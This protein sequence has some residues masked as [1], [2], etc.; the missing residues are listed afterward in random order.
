MAKPPPFTPSE[1]EG[2]RNKWCQKR[3]D[4]QVN[5]PSIFC[6]SD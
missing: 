4:K 3:S 5:A 6:T 2:A 1:V